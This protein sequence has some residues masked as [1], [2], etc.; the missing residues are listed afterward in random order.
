MQFPGVVFKGAPVVCQALRGQ[1]KHAWEPVVRAVTHT[2]AR[3]KLWKR[4][5]V[6]SYAVGTTA[7]SSWS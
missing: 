5:E 6:L 4:Q 2:A 7:V 3:S 1:G